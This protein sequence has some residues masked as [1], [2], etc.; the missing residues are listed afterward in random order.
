MA[1]ANPSFGRYRDDCL[2]IE[3]VDTDAQLNAPYLM[4]DQN[5]KLSHKLKQAKGEDS[6]I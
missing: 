4:Q 1:A 3:R 5:S 6:K 2:G